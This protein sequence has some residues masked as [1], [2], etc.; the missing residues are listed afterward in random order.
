MGPLVTS[1]ELERARRQRI[2][3]QAEADFDAIPF[4]RA[5][6]SA[7]GQVAASLREA[8]RKTS[9]RAYDALIA[10]VAVSRATPLFTMNPRDFVG[11]HDLVVVS[12]EA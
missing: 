11:I 7:F 10:A 4:D 1:D 9:A 12:V 2:L 3:Q 5:A 6:A 8:G